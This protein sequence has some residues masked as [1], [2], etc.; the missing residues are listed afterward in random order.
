MARDDWRLFTGDGRVRRV[1]FP[2]PPPWRRFGPARATPPA[3]PYLI[4]PGEA[5]VVNAALHLRRPLLVTGHPGT[6][7]S[8]LAHAVAHELDLGRVLTWP[9]NSRSTL[10]DALYRYDAIGR[11]RETSLRR[12][13]GEPDG[14]PGI[15][16]FVRLGPL[17]TAL[18]PAERPRVLL[19]DE[20]DKGDV[21]LPNDLLAVFE[22]GEFEI[23]ELARLPREQERVEVLADDPDAEPVPVVRGRVRCSAFPVVVITSNGERDFPPAFL[24]RCVRLDLPDPDERRLREIVAAHLGEEALAGVDDLLE[25]FL[26]RRASRELATDQLL[27]AVFLRAGGVGLDAGGLLDAV[28]HKLGGTV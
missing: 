22:E 13:R 16:S 27:N 12:D 25:E 5:D 26:S 11:L 28:L 1:E 4:G 8:S 21:D 20:L 15:G 14:D 3:R 19:V 17:G 2:E 18:V 10:Q 24:R 23:P 6:G 9:V 7:K